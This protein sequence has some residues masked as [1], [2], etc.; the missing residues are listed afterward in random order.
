MNNNKIL[1]LILSTNDKRYENFIN[2]CT[3]TWV[4][5]ARKNDIRCI[6]YSGGAPYDKL[7]ND[8][9]TLNCD[10]SLK[11]TSF[12]LFSALKYIENSGIQYTHIYRTNLSSFIFV[13]PIILSNSSRCSFI[14]NKR[15]KSIPL[16]YFLIP[17]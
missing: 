17:Q 5:N 9:L 8:Q 15:F 7:E 16:K 1:I 3:T 4:K 2:N 12:K 6:F 10:D 13:S 14:L 11:G